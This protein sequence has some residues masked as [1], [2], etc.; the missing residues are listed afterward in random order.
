MGHLMF[1]VLHILAIV[2]GFVLLFIT[3]PLHLIY[4]GTRKKRVPL[5]QRM[6]QT[7]SEFWNRKIF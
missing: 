1:I 5:V 6:L 4:A 7:K 3:V 2:F